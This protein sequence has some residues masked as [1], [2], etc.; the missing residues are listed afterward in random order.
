[1]RIPPLLYQMCS[2]KTTSI[3][4]TLRSRIWNTQP[5][6]QV[7]H[8]FPTT[9]NPHLQVFPTKKSGET[10]RR[11][12]DCE[13][14][15][16]CLVI[17]LTRRVSGGYDSHQFLDCGGATLR[18]VLFVLVRCLFLQQSPTTGQGGVNGI[19]HFHCIIIML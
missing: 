14:F 9:F 15:V 7:Y 18:S 2:Q 11:R 13:C 10:G 5:I 6:H 1:M 12:E 16:C 8:I 17:H 3:T 19:L 4:L